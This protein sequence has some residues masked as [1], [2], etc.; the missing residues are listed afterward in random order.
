MVII[1]KGAARRTNNKCV[2]RIGQLGMKVGRY[3]KKYNIMGND[4]SI[5]LQVEFKLF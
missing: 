1:N 4:P 2:T 3:P 5:I